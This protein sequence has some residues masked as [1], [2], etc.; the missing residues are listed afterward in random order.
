[1]KNSFKLLAVFALIFLSVALRAADADESETWKPFQ[2]LIGDWVGIGSGKP[3]EGTGEFSLRYDLN[4][5]ILV[6]KNV[7]RIAPKPGEATTV[8]HEDLMVIYPQANKGNF[9]ADYF[10]SEGHVIHYSV[11]CAENKTVFESDAT[12]NGPKF[13]LTYELKTPDVLTID[14]AV[15]APGKDFQTY[16]SG[17]A[18]RK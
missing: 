4:K 7:N 9:R 3:G 16:I 14:F 13:R 8:N 10:D 11:S 5:K 6:R 2:Y 15:A 1:M 18:K 17:T 12:G